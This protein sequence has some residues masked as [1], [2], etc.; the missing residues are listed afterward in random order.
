MVD[1][2]P[3]QQPL[4]E[5]TAPTIR[6]LLLRP[7]TTIPEDRNHPL[8]VIE[9][10]PT[11]RL[12]GYIS[13]GTNVPDAQFAIMALVD[14]QQVEFFLGG[15][16][17]TVHLVQL[18]QNERQLF[19]FALREPL[20]PG[21]HDVMVVAE[22]DPFSSYLTRGVLGKK[23]RDGKV[24]F[25]YAAEYPFSKSIAVRRMVVVEGEAA[26][27]DASFPFSLHSFDPLPQEVVEQSQLLGAPLYVSLS[28]DVTKFLMAAEPALVAGEDDTLY[29]YT[30]YYYAPPDHPLATTHAALFAFFDNEQIPING[31][32]ALLWEVRTGEHHR[33][34]LRFAFPPTVTDGKVH[35]LRIFVVYGVFEDWRLYEEGDYRWI[36][37]FAL[38]LG[39]D[40]V[41]VVPQRE[42]VDYIWIGAANPPEWWSAA[43]DNE[44]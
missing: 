27:G 3:Y 9:L 34:P 1:E 32:M 38:I 6:G 33:I 10:Q 35:T 19:E 26:G 17:S 13:V 43:P 37:N 40:W 7:A 2:N 28:D 39:A 8:G 15:N 20:P 4:S 36:A 14:Y 12:E 44:P 11:Q 31:E 23:E 30:H 22:P 24:S 16:W 42:L 41:P 21:I 25:D 18:P 29:A 5:I